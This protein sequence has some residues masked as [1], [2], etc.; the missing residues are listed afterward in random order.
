MGKYKKNPII[1]FIYAVGDI[2]SLI[3]IG[4]G[5]LIVLILSGIFLGSLHVRNLFRKKF[6]KYN[7]RP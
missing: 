7:K 1:I 3:A 5:T 2:L 4:M 6:G